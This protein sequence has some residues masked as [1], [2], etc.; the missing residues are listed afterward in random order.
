MHG[1]LDWARRVSRDPFERQFNI[2]ATVPRSRLPVRIHELRRR[3][4]FFFPPQRRHI[5]AAC[6]VLGR[7]SCVNQSGAAVIRSAAEGPKR[8]RTGAPGSNEP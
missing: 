3:L 5:K 2:V 1:R 7:G 4:R 6:E 8:R